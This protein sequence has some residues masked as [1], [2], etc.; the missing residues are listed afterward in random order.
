MVI[1]IHLQQIEDLKQDLKMANVDKTS[2]IAKARESLRVEAEKMKDDILNVS[3]I[4]S[5]N[6]KFIY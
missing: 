6:M 2:A 5:F 3:Q 1:L 4:L